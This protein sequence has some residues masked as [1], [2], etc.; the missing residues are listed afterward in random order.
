MRTCVCYCIDMNS[1]TATPQT[2]AK[3]SA[4]VRERLEAL[5]KMH[6]SVIAGQAVTRWSEL[7]EIGTYA[8]PKNLLSF[9]DAL[10]RLVG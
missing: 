4:Y 3:A 5:P 8:N 6:T 1:V 9:E 2:A 10:T 7:Y